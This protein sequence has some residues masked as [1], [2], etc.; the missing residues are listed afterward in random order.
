[1]QKNWIGKSKGL[2]INFISENG[3]DTFTAFTTRPDTI[4]GVT[5]IAISINHDLASN[6]SKKDEQIKN[7]ITKYQR[8]K[9]SEETSAKVE[10]DGVFTGKY[11]LHPILKK[12]SNMDC[13]LFLI[14]MVP[15]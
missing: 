9:L 5:Y 7:F 10:K 11:C 1:M 3:S 13:N 6:L 15:E 8:Q 2:N 12:N 4:F 14:T